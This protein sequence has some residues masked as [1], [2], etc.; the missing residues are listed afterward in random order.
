MKAIITI[1]VLSGLLM[2]GAYAQTPSG[3]ANNNSIY[4]GYVIRLIPAGSN[5][6]GYDIFFRSKMVAHQPRNPFTLAPTGLRSSDDA[7]KV[8]RWQVQ[9]LWHD[10]SHAPVVNRLLSKNVAK[11]LN[12]TI[13]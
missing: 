13:N 7:L 5:G 11:Q 2:S 10:R 8:A 12:I 3:G 6:F 1:I 9:Q 4:M